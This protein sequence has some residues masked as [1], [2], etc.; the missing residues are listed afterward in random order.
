MWGATEVPDQAEEYANS[1][2]LYAKLSEKEKF[3]LLNATSIT[4]A[5]I[6]AYGNSRLSKEELESC[7]L[8]FYL[9]RIV[10]DLKY[11]EKNW[12]HPRES[13]RLKCQ[14][15]TL[16]EILPHSQGHFV[17]PCEIIVS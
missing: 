7:I 1:L 15:S 10:L 14:M 17:A 11:H 9:E 5:G 12:L 2:L 3:N 16:Y 13:K 4:V 6:R 8:S